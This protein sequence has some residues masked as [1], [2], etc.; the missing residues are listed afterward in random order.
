VVIWLFP[1]VLVYCVKKNLATLQSGLAFSE[2]TDA[3]SSGMQKQNWSQSN[4]DRI[5]NYNGVVDE[6]VFKVRKFF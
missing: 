5:Y 1:L 2:K 4:D 6:S 3:A